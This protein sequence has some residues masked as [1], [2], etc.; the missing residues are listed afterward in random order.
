MF[1]RIPFC[2]DHGQQH[3]DNCTLEWLRTDLDADATVASHNILQLRDADC[4]LEG[5]AMAA[6]MIRLK[7]CG[8]D[9]GRHSVGESRLRPSVCFTENK[10]LRWRISCLYGPFEGLL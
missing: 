10:L 9:F 6:S 3:A 2:A 8:V 4:K 1:P 7:I 5:P